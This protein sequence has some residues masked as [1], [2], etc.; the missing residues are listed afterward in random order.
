MWTA[1]RDMKGCET[2]VGD[3]KGCG[4]LKGTQAAS[5]GEGGKKGCA[6]LRGAGRGVDC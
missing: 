1:E 2:G 6:L 5:I 4:V 3:A